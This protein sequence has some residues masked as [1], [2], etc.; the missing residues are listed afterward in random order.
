[1]NKINCESWQFM[2]DNSDLSEFGEIKNVFVR[3]RRKK[4]KDSTE[5]GSREKED[6]IGALKLKKSC[7]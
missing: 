5:Q 2:M 7:S 1:M 4:K 6:A 3:M